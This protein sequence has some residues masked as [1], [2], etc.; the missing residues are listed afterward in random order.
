MGTSKEEEAG[1]I[2]RIA[3]AHTCADPRTVV[4]MHL[5]TNAAITTV[6]C[7]RRPEYFASLTIRKVILLKLSRIDLSVAV[8]IELLDDVLKLIQ[9]VEFLSRIFDIKT[10]H[11]HLQFF[12]GLVSHVVTSVCIRYGHLFLKHGNNSWVTRR[13]LSK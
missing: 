7:P 2:S 4:I 3:V 5:N 12:F 1:K 10:L 13:A 9:V 11:G 8:F 6:K